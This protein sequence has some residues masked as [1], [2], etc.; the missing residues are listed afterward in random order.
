MSGPL[1]HVDEIGGGYGDIRIIEE[2]SLGVDRGE[3]LCIAGRNGVGKTTLLKLITGFLPLMTGAIHLDG[4]RIDPLPAH[5]RSRVGMTYAPQENVV[6]PTLS[7]RDNLNLHS[8]RDALARYGELFEAFPRIGERLDQTAG[9]LSGGERKILSFCRALGEGNTLTL[10]DEPTEGVQPENIDRMTRIIRDRAA[11]GAAF[12]IVEQN[13][14]LIEAAANR[15]MVLDQGRCTLDTGN[16]PG[17]RDEI[18][19]YL[20]L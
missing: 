14:A 3:V 9:T 15:V 2:M 19:S 6:F 12:I 16:H 17:I 18:A 13:L 11:A 7:V 4:Q 1:L 10:L 20:E 5:G 8:G